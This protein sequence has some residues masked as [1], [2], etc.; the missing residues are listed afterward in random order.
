MS[1]LCIGASMGI[2]EVFGTQVEDSSMI[3]ICSNQEMWI[4]LMGTS[5]KELG[6]DSLNILDVASIYARDRQ[7]SQWW[8][9]KRE[10][11]AAF[12][13]MCRV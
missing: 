10:I 5:C 8:C 9:C 3:S 7:K 13:N 11:Q 1:G 2:L 4:L 12:V 6:P